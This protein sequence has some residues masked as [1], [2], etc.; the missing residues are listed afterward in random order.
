MRGED[1]AKGG[2]KD[3]FFE[4]VL[5]ALC[6]RSID[7]WAQE[8]ADVKQKDAAAEQ[9]VVKDTEQPLKKESVEERLG[10]IFRRMAGRRWKFRMRRLERR[11]SRKA[12]RRKRF[13]W[14]TDSAVVFVPCLRRFHVTRTPKMEPWVVHL[15]R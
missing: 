14:R 15:P 7:L 8:S 3:H 6:K 13:T 12:L 5:C 10:W 1:G 4:D 9:A 11:T 2:D